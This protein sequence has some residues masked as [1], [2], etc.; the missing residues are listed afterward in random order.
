MGIAGHLLLSLP[1]VDTGIIS[2][3]SLIYPHTSPAKRCYFRLNVLGHDFGALNTQLAYF[4]SM[5][6]PVNYS[7]WVFKQEEVY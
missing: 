5:R 1:F 2:H 6:N 3:I 4:L 7:P